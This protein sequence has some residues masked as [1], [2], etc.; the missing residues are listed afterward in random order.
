MTSKG[1]GQT[2]KTLK[3]NIGMVFPGT[4]IERHKEEQSG[5]AGTYFGMRDER[6]LLKIIC[7]V[8]SRL[9]KFSAFITNVSVLF[10]S[11]MPTHSGQKSYTSFPYKSYTAFPLCDMMPHGLS[12]LEIAPTIS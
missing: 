3:S 5:R 7:L 6:Y 10:Q 4:Q 9:C 12:E 2:L 1:Q 11:H 8:L